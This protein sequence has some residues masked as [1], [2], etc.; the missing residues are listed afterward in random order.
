MRLGSVEKAILPS[1]GKSAYAHK[2]A[3]YRITPAGREWVSL[4]ES[5]RRAAYDKLLPGLVRAHPTFT[6]FL[7]VTGAIGV[8]VRRTHIDLHVMP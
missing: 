5:D 7:S 1:S 4:L 3:R 2:E 6:C 8:S